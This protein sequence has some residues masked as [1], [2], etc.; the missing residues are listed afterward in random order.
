MLLFAVEMFICTTVNYADA[1]NE[2]IEG[3]LTV[4]KRIV[5]E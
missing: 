4:E 1:T 5:I 2:D 3:N